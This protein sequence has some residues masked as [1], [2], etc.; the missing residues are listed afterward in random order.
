MKAEDNTDGN[1]G[2]NMELT[3]DRGAHG[4]EEKRPL[5]DATVPERLVTAR[6]GVV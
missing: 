4:S 5:M 2:E 1:A 3:Q 6:T